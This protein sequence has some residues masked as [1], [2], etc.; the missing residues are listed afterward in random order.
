[1]KQLILLTLLFLSACNKDPLPELSIQPGGCM[2][3]WDPQD[4]PQPICV[5]R[6]TKNDA[7]RTPLDNTITIT[8][9]GPPLRRVKLTANGA[10]RYDD[11]IPEAGEVSLPLEFPAETTQLVAS[12]TDGTASSGRA[13]SL[14][15]SRTHIFPTARQ[16]RAE[17]EA[18]ELQDHPA[19]VQHALD[20]LD[21]GQLALSPPERAYFLGQLGGVLDDYREG[22][23]GSALKTETRTLALK[24][25]RRAMEE[26][27][28]QNL[29]SVE[30]VSLTRSF[31]FLHAV[32]AGESLDK[33]IETLENPSTNKALSM[34]IHE[35]IINH[36]NLS[37]IYELIGNF[38]KSTRNINKAI[39]LLKKN[40]TDPASLVS[41]HSQRAV[42][43]QYI[44]NKTESDS[45]KK[46][47]IRLLNSITDSCKKLQTYNTLGWIDILQMQ[48]G[49]RDTQARTYLKAA[50]QLHNDCAEKNKPISDFDSPLVRLNLARVALLEFEQTAHRANPNDRLLNEAERYLAEAEALLPCKEPE[51]DRKQDCQ[52]PEAQVDALELRGR[53]ALLRSGSPPAPTGAVP[54]VDDR[55]GQELAR[56]ALAAFQALEKLTSTKILTPSYRWAALVGQADAYARLNDLKQ[57]SALY[58]RAERLMQRIAAGLPLAS[59]RQMFVAQ[60]EAGTARHVSLLLDHAQDAQAAFQ[61][62]RSARSG[63]LRA[64]LPSTASSA[65]A[66]EWAEQMKSY[67]RQF[68]E[69]ERAQH[70]LNEASVDMKEKARRALQDA[71]QALQD[72]LAPMYGDT[73]ADSVQDRYRAPD[74]DELLLTCYPLSAPLQQGARDWLCAAADSKGPYTVRR[75]IATWN[76]QEAAAILAAFAE[77][78]RRAKRLTLLPYGGM[79]EVVWETVPFDGQPLT[80]ERSVSYG[81]DLPRHPVR[82]QRATDAPILAVVNPQGNLPAAL[83][84][85][86]ALR[87]AA[88]RA[89]RTLSLFSGAPRRGGHVLT[90]LL[91][92]FS[93]KDRPADAKQVL[94]SLQAGDPFLYY[95]HA[96]ASQQ[97]GLDSHLRFADNS[98]IAARDIMALPTVPSRVLLVGCETAVSDPQAPADD[99]GLTQ[100]FLLRGSREVLATTR[101][102][103][104]AHA[105]LL[106][107]TLLESEALSPAVPLAD[108]V[109]HALMP[110][111]QRSPHP[112]W[113]AFRVYQP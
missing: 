29:Y 4:K 78:L 61:A 112:D 3:Y 81:L 99:L 76:T 68:A 74:D 24:I 105:A 30:A 51:A 12:S 94:T 106:L 79:R 45:S 80:A 72:A 5:L 25:L 38:E 75:S 27:H 110:L 95:G 13:A 62:I 50:Y 49:V 113:D 104:D 57:A 14:L 58:R 60:F 97:A 37:W 19:Q 65:E 32:N 6:Q 91:A 36:Y 64:L 54:Q 43:M 42:T 98:Q 102:V 17:I 16:L 23:D 69:R 20:S 109:R 107:Q 28:Q 8:V 100:A 86:E 31:G 71:D 92:L 35:G 101:Q 111:R 90:T 89:G 82:A 7:D 47:T 83:N 53:R 2:I 88:T 96:A 73:G 48:S 93:P 11:E 26:A 22:V 34:S 55:P 1:M 40:P 66:N 77:P 33:I 9:S 87:A 44:N 108:T 84:I 56:Q 15:L 46:E 63:A 59:R 67:F 10:T 18:H 85:V 39:A 41:I 52:K 21:K 103:S 70:D